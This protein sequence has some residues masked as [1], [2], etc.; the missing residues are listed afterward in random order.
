MF[1]S[2]QYIRR[3]ILLSKTIRNFFASVLLGF[4][5]GER[6]SLKICASEGAINSKV[7]QKISVLRVIFGA[8][9]SEGKTCQPKF[10]VKDKF[11][12]ASIL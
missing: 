7:R 2:K 6:Q 5:A 3:R 8:W 11:G 1:Q 9:T 12:S 10:Y 4:M